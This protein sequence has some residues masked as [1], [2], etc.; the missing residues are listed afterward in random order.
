MGFVH[1]SD[2]MNF[3]QFIFVCLLGF[4]IDEE[5]CLG[6]NFWLRKDGM[7]LS[8]KQCVPLHYFLNELLKAG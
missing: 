4:S 1:K 5:F 6:G 8:L 3:I 7:E 2:L